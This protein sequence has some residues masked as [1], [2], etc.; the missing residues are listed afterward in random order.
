M[1]DRR[2]YPLTVR[3][4]LAWAFGG[5]AL[6]VVVVA[7]LAIRALGAVDAKFENYVSG[8]D[9]RALAAHAVHE[10]IDAR[11]IA[12]RNLVLVTRPEDVEAEK[13]AVLAAHEQVTQRLDRLNVLAREADVP[14]QVRDMIRRIDD[15]ERRYAPV[16]LAIVDLAL[17]KR[18]QEAV[19]K[20]NDECRPLLAELVL[21]SD[22]YSQFTARR[23]G[24]LI[25]EAGATYRTQRNLLLSACLLALLLAVAAGVAITRSLI[26]ALGAEPTELKVAVARVADGDLAV[27]LAVRPEDEGSVLAAMARMQASLAGVASRV[28]DSALRLSEAS[29]A[30]SSGNAELAH[31]TQVQTEA[32][33]LTG[34]SMSELGLAV[35]HNAE[36]AHQANE[37]ARSASSVASAGGQVVGEVVS[38]MRDINESSRK[39]AEIIGV[40]DSIAFQTNILALNAAVEAARAGEQGRGFAVVAAE[41]RSLAGRSAEA[42][43]E[44]KA[45]IST[46][47]QRV[48]QGAMLVDR[49]GATMKDIVSSI[50][51]VND[52]MAEISAASE[53][54]REGVTRVARAVDDMNQ[55]NQANAG[56]VHDMADAAQHLKAESETLLHSVGVFRLDAT[57][58]TRISQPM[59]PGTGFPALAG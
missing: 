50:Q 46:S 57:R 1:N 43:R 29:T 14:D 40:I 53:Q 34:T 20:M 16:A 58:G 9:A 28:R 17:Q 38:T 56:L 52:I 41:V 3:A 26:H 54:Q 2:M 10:A 13:R 27:P 4:R 32:L 7:V 31:R 8:I 45:L 55:A 11:A 6:I 18:T 5:L 49:A 44:I 19:A 42:A 35:Q 21:A 15:V 25:A 23:A 12:A 51:R 30:M 47:V 37:L 59:L 48:E 22:S 24:D 39:I 36:S 33:A